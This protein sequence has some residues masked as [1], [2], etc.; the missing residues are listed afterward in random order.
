M[1]RLQGHTVQRIEVVEEFN[2]VIAACFNEEEEAATDQTGED[3]LVER[4]NETDAACLLVIDLL[5]GK[6]L[7]KLA[8]AENEYPSAI[9]VKVFD[10][11]KGGVNERQL[12]VYVGAS[13]LVETETGKSQYYS[14]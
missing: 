7:Q 3:G 6:T 13:Q 9:A 11:K 2:L 10:R 8:F 4:E 1:I 12:K 5:T 14:P